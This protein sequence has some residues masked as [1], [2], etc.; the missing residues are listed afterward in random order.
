MTDKISKSWIM[1]IIAFVFTMIF[2][3]AND[4]LATYGIMIT[5]TEMIYYLSVFLSVAGLGTVNSIK[6]KLS[7][8][9]PLTPGD[10]TNIFE[11]HA[12]VKK[13]TAITKK[14]VAP[15]TLG[16]AGSKFQTNFQRGEGGNKIPYGQIYLWIK[17]EGVRSYVT[18]I[19]K[20]AAGVPI[21]IDQSSELDE[22]NNIETTRIELFDKSGEPMPRGKYILQM[23]GDGTGGDAQG[24]KKDEFE[25]V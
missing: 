22:D 14:L 18:A 4:A 7:N 8:R 17:I 19:L 12:K 24:I 25:I 16:P 21:Q 13:V 5:E 1:T 20:T 11:P 2:P 23:Q 6:K 9:K 3:I 15:P 10:A